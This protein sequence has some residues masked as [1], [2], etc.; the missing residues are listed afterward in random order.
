MYHRQ[1]EKGLNGEPCLD[2]SGMIGSKRCEA[3]RHRDSIAITITAISTAALAAVFLTLGN[4]ERV[5]PDGFLEVAHAPMG[6]LATVMYLEGGLGTHHFG[7]IP[8]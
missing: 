8:R 7:N 3:K 2:R 6:S 4:G 5:G 1:D